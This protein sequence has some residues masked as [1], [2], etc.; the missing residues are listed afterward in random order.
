MLNWGLPHQ[1]N[2]E[3]T[4][5]KIKVIWKNKNKNLTK[6]DGL[7]PFPEKNKKRKVVFTAAKSLEHLSQPSNLFTGSFYFSVALKN[8]RRK[9]SLQ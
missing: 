1:F 7:K 3:K 5:H 9:N 4:K 8:Y 2:N 6:I